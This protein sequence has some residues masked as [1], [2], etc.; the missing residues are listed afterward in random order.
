MRFPIMDRVFLKSFLIFFLFIDV[1]HSIE[2]TPEHFLILLKKNSLKS[3]EFEVLESHSDLLSVYDLKDYDWTWFVQTQKGFDGSNS[4]NGTNSSEYNRNQVTSGVQKKGF[5]GETFTFHFEI[6][7]QEKIDRSRI[8]DPER[9]YFTSVGFE[10]ELDLRRNYLGTVDQLNQKKSDLLKT[11]RKIQIVIN[12][13]QFESKSLELFWNTFLQQETLKEFLKLKS[14][15]QALEK[16]IKFKKNQGST[17][18]GELEQVLAEVENKELQVSMAQI[19]LKNQINQIKTLLKSDDNDFTLNV[20]PERNK[21]PIIETKSPRESTNQTLMARIN[22]E[23]ADVQN[24]IARFNNKSKL[25]LL[26]GST[27]YGM[28][29]NFQESQSESLK[30]NQNSRYIGLKWQDSF[31][32]TNL[33]YSQYLDAQKQAAKLSEQ[34]ISQ[35]QL[36]DILISRSNIQSLITSIDSYNKQIILRKQSLKEIEKS[37]KVGRIDIR[38]LI[39]SMNNLSMTVQ[40][41]LKA[42]SDLEIE[43]LHFKELQDLPFEKGSL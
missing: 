9:K 32:D 43:L 19:R 15:Y 38:S 12:R 17:S 14:S 37:Y 7:D 2:L 24:E 16:N 6:V 34:N 1:C 3:E 36:D 4:L 18:P 27:G 21:A 20:K 40:S 11:S 39:E 5:W 13:T 28:D 30:W 26:I 33:K 25:S 29:S 31:G 23:I 10:F 8:L 42:Q 35:Q 22:S 41:R